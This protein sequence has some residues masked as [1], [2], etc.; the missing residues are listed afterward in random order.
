MAEEPGCVLRVVS[1]DG[2]SLPVTEDFDPSRINVRVAGGRVTENL[3]L[4]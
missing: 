3:G 1:E 4:Y 2:R